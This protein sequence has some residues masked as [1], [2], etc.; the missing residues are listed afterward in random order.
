MYCIKRASRTQRHDLGDVGERSQ[1]D[2]ERC[3]GHLAGGGKGAKPP[4]PLISEL[5]MLEMNWFLIPVNE[6]AGIIVL[7]GPHL[8]LHAGPQLLQPDTEPRCEDIRFAY[9]ERRIG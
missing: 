3:C 5:E 7:D 8:D 1:F 6:R 2:V 4:L 9:D